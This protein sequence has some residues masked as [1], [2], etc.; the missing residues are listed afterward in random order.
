MIDHVADETELRLLRKVE[1]ILGFT[2]HLNERISR[3]DKQGDQA[4]TGC[5]LHM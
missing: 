5:T 2:L 3:R 4:D 1:A